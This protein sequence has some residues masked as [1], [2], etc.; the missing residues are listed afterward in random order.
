MS[1]TKLF[2]ADDHQIVIDALKHQIQEQSNDFELIGY[3]LN[4]KDTLK[5]L[6]ENHVDILILDIHMPEMDGEELIEIAR[7][8]FPI[9][10]ILV[11]SMSDNLKYI[12]KMLRSGAKGYILKN[13]G[14]EYIIEAL[15]QIRD[16]KEF[17]QNDVAQIAV[18]D[19]IPDNEKKFRDNKERILRSIKDHEGELLGWLTLDL[20]AKEIADKMYKSPSTIETWKKN[21][22]AKTGTKSAMGLVRF[23]IENGFQKDKP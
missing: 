20:T 13:K 2:I 19:L 15:T 23:A 7:N 5:Q 3:A 18:R 8:E 4:G 11:L 16:G 17:I 10:K 12:Q 9:L 22:M 14:A 6:R 21:L 1:K